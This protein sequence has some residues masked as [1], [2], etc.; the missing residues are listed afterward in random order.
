MAKRIILLSDGTG[1]AAAKVWRT[2]VWRTFE[3][4]DLSSSDQVAF[5]DDGVGTS[6]F[7]PV[8]ILGGAF[9]Y[10]LKRNV[11]DLYKF[12]CR[13]YS[14]AADYRARN[15]DSGDDDI[16]AFGFSRGA[17][18]IRV[19]VGLIADQGLVSYATEA[20]L[21]TKAKAAYRKF[22]SEHFRTWLGI[23]R[24][25]RWVRNKFVLGEHD[26]T[27]RPVAN[28][29]FLGLW[30]TVAA[31]GL[32]VDEMARGVSRYLFPL[33]LPTRQLSGKVVRACHALSLDDERTT[34]HPVLWDEAQQPPPPSVAT[35][36][37]SA[38]RIT[39]VWFAGVHSNVGGGYPDD[40]LA[41]VALTWILDE[42]AA[43]GLRLKR[44]PNQEPDAI[45]RS[46]SAQD[47]D[48][49][50]YDSR[51]GLG[52]YYRYGPRKLQDLCNNQSDDSRERVKIAL[53]KI[54][55]SVLERIRQ[56]AHLY[57]P[58]GIP[59]R[60]AVVD[61]NRNVLSNPSA[62]YEPAA[63]APQR[64]QD[65]ETVWNTVWR[66]RV[67]YFLSVCASVYLVAYPLFWIVRP[68]SE[69]TTKLRFVTD[70][71]GF[72]DSFL[73]P[74]AGRWF[75]TYSSDPWWFIEWVVIVAI[76][77]ILGSRLQAYITDQMRQVWSFG[78]C[79]HPRP[80]LVAVNRRSTKS[81]LT[82]S[83]V[84]LAAIY[85]LISPDG[86]GIE[87]G[88]VIRRPLSS[89]FGF[90]IPTVK[91]WLGW[92]M[93]SG[94][95]LLFAATAVTML[96]PDGLI[97][98]VRLSRI[99]QYL[100]WSTKMRVAPLLFAILF[101][102]MGVAFLSHF[103]F[104]IRD[105]VGSFCEPSRVTITGDTLEKTTQ[106]KYFDVGKN[107]LDSA[108]PERLCFATGWKLERGHKYLFSI[109]TRLPSEEHLDPKLVVATP[110]AP[111]WT[112]WDHP[113]ST[114]GVSISGLRQAIPKNGAP[115]NDEFP[116]WKRIAAVALYPLRR[117]FDRPWGSVIVRF[118]SDANEES[119]IDPDPANAYF[120]LQSEHLV[121]R[122]DGELF[123]YL[124]K[125]V[126]GF[127]GLEMMPSRFISA[128]GL[129]RITIKE[130]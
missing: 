127:W 32:P 93:T 94:I 51:S 20:E 97:Q 3:S 64:A 89:L 71:L 4:I 53:P 102:Y 90:E 41:Q 14:S 46:S 109:S 82:W 48:G 121:P 63:L 36:P 115:S 125:P 112:F 117:T 69:A 124:D 86:L 50:L 105:G 70:V 130:D 79:G 25:F 77:L 111:R 95:A 26:K 22:R 47:K 12:V 126:L 9:G 17:F 27:Q 39:Q 123:V 49:R 75:R 120:E 81:T 80:G 88:E 110:E 2:N 19:V 44:R 1:N 30:D 55:C 84:L 83:V 58:I 52:G 37:T 15:V 98:T 16:F 128:T 106:I 108:D 60:Y 100:L 35:W 91:Q 24:L 73:P 8:A 78:L 38:E 104:N 122:R 11:L 96:L 23:E 40:S 92:Y 29:A 54:H 118:G 61:G 31:Y 56:N 10:G 99:Y 129:A 72:F 85:L 113:S 107:Q 103:I 28:I 57:A 13:N 45:I 62:A 6:S 114:G 67:V 116:M 74:V 87:L 42:A 34:F 7:K 18:T 43:R 76:L 33:E 68:S 65:Q 21:E 5:Y 59:Q 66:R 101:L 119:F